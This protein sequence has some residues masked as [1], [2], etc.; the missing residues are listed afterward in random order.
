M[1]AGARHPRVA[2]IAFVDSANLADEKQEMFDEYL[3]DLLTKLRNDGAA[4]TRAVKFLRL[5]KWVHQLLGDFGQVSFSDKL[6]LNEAR[7]RP[8]KKKAAAST[9]DGS[10]STPDKPKEKETADRIALKKRVR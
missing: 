1:Y 4:D 3:K 5:T 6:R 2:A 7:L 8:K 9:K 10:A